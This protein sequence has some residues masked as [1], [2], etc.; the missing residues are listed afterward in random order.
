[1]YSCVLVCVGNPRHAEEMTRLALSVSEKGARLIFLRVAPVVNDWALREF[2]SD[3]AFMGSLKIAGRPVKFEK[4]VS[5]SEDCAR[6]ILDAAKK[7]G[8]DLVVMGAVPHKGFFGKLANDI[9]STVMSHA[10]AAVVMVKKRQ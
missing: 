7:D 9:G 6:A 10:N 1:M 3:L 5:E 2:D 8:C 4:R